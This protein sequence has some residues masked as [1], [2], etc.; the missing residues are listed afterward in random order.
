MHAPRP[1]DVLRLHANAAKAAKLLDWQAE[2]SLADGV[3]RLIAWHEEQ[4]TDWKQ[5]LDEDVP[6]NWKGE[7]AR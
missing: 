6:H 7:A 2:V 1:G 3:A 5:A 4:G